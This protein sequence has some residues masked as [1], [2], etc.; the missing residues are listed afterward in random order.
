MFLEGQS[1]WDT[2]TILAGMGFIVIV[3]MIIFGAAASCVGEFAGAPSICL[4]EGTFTGILQSVD[5]FL[6]ST[7]ASPSLSRVVE[8]LLP[9]SSS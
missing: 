5:A 3:L 1:G 2:Q 9:E 6:S 8:R 4:F 7:F